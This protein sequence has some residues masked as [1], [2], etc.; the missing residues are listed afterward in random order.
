MLPKREYLEAGIQIG[1]GAV[2]LLTGK[3]VP[4]IY[5]RMNEGTFIPF[6]RDPYTGRISF[7][8]RDVL[9]FIETQPKFSCTAQYKRSEKIERME[10]ARRGKEQK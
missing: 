2:R 3:S 6:R 10:L 4:T 9:A 1:V 8:S 5:R 7:D